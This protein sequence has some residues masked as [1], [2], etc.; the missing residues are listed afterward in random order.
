[1]VQG[2]LQAASERPSTTIRAPGGSLKRSILAVLML[3]L[4]VCSMEAELAGMFG[5]T[6]GARG[7]ATGFGTTSV[8]AAGMAVDLEL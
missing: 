3:G 6:A 1:M 2:A 7:T 5:V 4:S 8:L